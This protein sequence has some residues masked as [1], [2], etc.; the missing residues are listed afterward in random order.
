MRTNLENKRMKSLFSLGS[1]RTQKKH[2]VNTSKSPVAN[3]VLDKICN[4]SGTKWKLMLYCE[5]EF[6]R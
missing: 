6:M 5:G 1:I 3:L 2:N 4:Y